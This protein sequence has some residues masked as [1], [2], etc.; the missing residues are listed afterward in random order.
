MLCYFETLNIVKFLWWN[1]SHLSLE[2]HLVMA[3]PIS[4]PTVI[5]NPNNSHFSCD[6]L[7]TISIVGP[8]YIT[9]KLCRWFSTIESYL[10]YSF[11]LNVKESRYDCIGESQRFMYKN[12]FICRFGEHR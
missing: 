11:K 7:S 6:A 3:E 10:L 2:S 5:W 4:M 8:F 12:S 1:I 9:L